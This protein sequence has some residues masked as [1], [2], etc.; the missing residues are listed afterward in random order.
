MTKKIGPE[1]VQ[2]LKALGAAKGKL[3]RAR[4][5]EAEAMREVHDLIREGF[6]MNISG[7]KLSDASGLS[8]PRVYQVRDEMRDA[9]AQ[10]RF[11]RN[12]ETKVAVEAAEADIDDA[13][14]VEV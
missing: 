4:L 12:P 5:K 7:I 8:L 3:I 2:H 14:E 13:V 1:H 9:E 6:A 11:E 10:A